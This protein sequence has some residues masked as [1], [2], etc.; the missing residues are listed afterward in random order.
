MAKR[1]QLIGGPLDG[2]T[3]TKPAGKFAWV[4]RTITTHPGADLRLLPGKRAMFA[5]GAGATSQPRK[6]AALYE[7]TGSAMLYAGHR[8]FLCGACGAF[9]PRCEGGSEKRQCALGGADA[10]R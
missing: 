8:V 4:R 10:D 7:D 2:H 5:T 6:A 3:I 1:R 9:H